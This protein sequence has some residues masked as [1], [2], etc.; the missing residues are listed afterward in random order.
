M[1][2]IETC[3]IFLCVAVVFLCSGVC[4]AET[5][6]VSYTSM[7]GNYSVSVPDG[8]KVTHDFEQYHYTEDNFRHPTEPAFNLNIRYYARYATHRLPNGWLEMYADGNDYCSQTINPLSTGN[9]S[10]KT[11]HDVNINGKGSKRFVVTAEKH[12]VKHP[13]YLF[14]DDVQQLIFPG[15]HAYTVIP[16]NSGFYVLTYLAPQG[17]FKKYEKSYEQMVSSFNLLTEY[18][19]SYTT[20]VVTQEVISYFRQQLH[21]DNTHRKSNAVYMLGK[22][23]DAESVPDLIRALEDSDSDVRWSAADALGEIGDNSVAEPLRNLLYDP[24]EYARKSATD[25]LKQINAPVTADELK[26]DGK[27]HEAFNQY[28]ADF[29]IMT[30]LYEGKTKGKLQEYRETIL[31]KKIIELALEM[32]PAPAVPKEAERFM[33]RGAVALKNAKDADDFN[34]AVTEFEKV[35][36]AAPWLADAYSNLGVVQDKAGRYE[37]AIR[38]LK[39]YLLAAPAAADRNAVEKL[40]YEIEYKQE[41]AKE[42]VET[43]RREQERYGWISGRWALTEKLDCTRFDMHM[44]LNPRTV[45]FIKSGDIVEAYVEGDRTKPLGLRCLVSD[46]VRWQRNSPDQFEQGRWIDIS[47]NV[48]S[49]QRR[50]KYTYPSFWR[51]DGKQ[52]RTV[53]CT[54]IKE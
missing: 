39:L 25:A 1:Q 19:N 3:V 11:I 46:R 2:F 10:A 20:M 15:E 23:K 43:E 38:S 44:T 14:G 40:I 6:S 35:T 34:D 26:K 9:K 52:D 31:R 18:P 27:L 28:M 41:K 16:V 30:K 22:I 37:P 53:D 45:E 8:W 24:A 12:E 48:S 7:F 29:K 4:L 32:K 49:D 5:K 42:K 51:E 21:S 36:L 13:G 47:V 33:T 54:L 50:I 17:N